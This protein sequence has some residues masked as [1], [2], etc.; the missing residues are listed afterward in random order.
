VRNFVFGAFLNLPL[1]LKSG[2]RNNDVLMTVQKLILLEQILTKSLK[3]FTPVIRFL[4][5]DGSNILKSI[6][7]PSASMVLA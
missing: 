4:S 7:I 1:S 5:M 2:Q 6:R 3:S